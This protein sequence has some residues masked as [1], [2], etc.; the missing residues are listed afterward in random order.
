VTSATNPHYQKLRLSLVSC[1]IYLSPATT[2]TKSIRLHQVRFLF[3]N[4]SADFSCDR[5]LRA[6]A[7]PADVA[8]V[9][10]SEEIAYRLQ[11]DDHERAQ[12][13][14]PPRGDTMIDFPRPPPLAA[15]MT[16]DEMR[17]RWRFLLWEE[18]LTDGTRH[19][20]SAASR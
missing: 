19:D 10:D 7:M 20:R 14:L 3:A 12:Y 6:R 8:R 9:M 16:L 17:A 5:R 4:L 18:P 1:P 2:R 13:G 15:P 11:L